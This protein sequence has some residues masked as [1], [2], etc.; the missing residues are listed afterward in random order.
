[1][2]DSF[3]YNV[4]TTA[5]AV[6]CSFSVPCLRQTP[7]ANY[8]KLTAIHVYVV[9]GSVYEKI[10]IEYF[11]TFH[12]LLSKEGNFNAINCRSNLPTR[13]ISIS[14]EKVQLFRCVLQ[15][16]VPLQ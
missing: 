13:F 10:T 2:F 8:R 14:K 12:H 3:S 4:N 7:G 15:R 16:I 11:Q 6:L 5:H 9:V 1:M